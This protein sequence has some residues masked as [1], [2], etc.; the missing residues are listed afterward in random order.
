MP[1]GR[2]FAQDHALWIAEQR[3]KRIEKAE[4]KKRGSWWIDLPREQFQ[5]EVQRR[6]QCI[7]N[8]RNPSVRSLAKVI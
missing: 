2:T 6:H 8:S 1:R 4:A 5:A 3:A 7:L